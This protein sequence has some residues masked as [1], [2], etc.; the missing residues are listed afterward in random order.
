MDVG[1]LKGPPEEAETSPV[2][3]PPSLTNCTLYLVKS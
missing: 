1:K 2:A 3:Q